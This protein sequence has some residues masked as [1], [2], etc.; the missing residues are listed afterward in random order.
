VSEGR[1]EAC[2]YR[3]LRGMAVA[4]LLLPQNRLRTGYRQV[5][6]TGSP[7]L[8]PTLWCTRIEA[9]GLTVYIRRDKVRVIISRAYCHKKAQT[10]L[11]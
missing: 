8:T 10:R 11:F 6:G 7:E 9:F 2:P 1:H 4:A 3:T 5:A